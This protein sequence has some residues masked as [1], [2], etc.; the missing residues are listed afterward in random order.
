MEIGVCLG[1]G[2]VLKY[3]ITLSSTN[4]GIAQAVRM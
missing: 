1:V 2:G 3:Q 4:K